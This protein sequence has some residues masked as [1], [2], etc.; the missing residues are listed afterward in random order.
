MSKRWV[1]YLAAFL[2]IIGSRIYYYFSER[3]CRN[4]L[5]KIE[6]W[7]NF[8]LQSCKPSSLLIFD[9][10]TILSAQD[11]LAQYENYPITFK[12][13]ALFNHPSLLIKKNYIHAHSLLLQKSSKKLTE[14]IIV[15]I[16]KKLK[17]KNCNVIGITSIESGSYGTIK[18]M[19]E[20]LYNILKSVDISF[21]EK[22]NDYIFCSFPEYNETYPVFYKG[23]IC[24]N[25]QLK[26]KIIAL[27][28]DKYKGKFERV[29]YIDN[30]KQSLCSIS[31]LCKEKNIEFV[32]YYYKGFERKEFKT[33]RA[34]FQL[35]CLI[36][37]QQWLND[38]EVDKIQ[39]TN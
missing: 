10:N 3:D 5:I 14:S 1:F 4:S 38:N 25:K 6:S 19:P 24:T 12:I 15:N 22:F 36:E 7:Q 21:D 2:L 33:K 18:N 34:L 8:D 23:I 26:N 20:W 37:K 27:F 9:I 16:M 13:R 17:E 28:L 31:K 35:N 30:N 39:T 11:A 29:V 32:G